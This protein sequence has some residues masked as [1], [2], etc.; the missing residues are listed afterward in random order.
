MTNDKAPPAHERMNAL[1]MT[2]ISKR[3]P[4][5]TALD[6]VDLDVARG[7]VVALVGENGAGK[8]T[9]MKILAGIHQPDAGTIR[10]NNETVVIR[11]P[12]DS[13][14]Y[15]IGIIHQELEVIDS[16]DIAGNIFLGREPTFGPFRCCSSRRIRGG[17]PPRDDAP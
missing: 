12:R 2:G 7:E 3:F 4:G 15:G 6:S 11:S 9:L 5:V 8:S 1:Q 14:R 10:I 17:F 16:L 13:A